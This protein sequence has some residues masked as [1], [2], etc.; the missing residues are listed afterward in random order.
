MAEHLRIGKGTLTTTLANIDTT[1]VPNSHIRFVK[2]ITLT[3]TTNAVRW[4]TITLAGTNIVYQYILAAVG[5]ENTITIPFM[6]HVMSSG[7][8]IQ[9]VAESAAIE[10]Y[11]SGREIDVS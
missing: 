6:D 1:G 7:E 11:I 9:G 2:A 10:F 4:A 5:G 8:R 3:N